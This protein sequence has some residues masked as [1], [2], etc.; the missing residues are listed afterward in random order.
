MAEAMAQKEP[1]LAGVKARTTCRACDSKRLV[2]ALDFGNPFVSN[3]ADVPAAKNWPR[4]PLEVVLC[5]DCTL[6][7]LRHTTPSDW[8]YR[9]YWYKSGVNGAMREAL[10]DITREATEFVALRSGDHV[11]DIGCNDGTLLRSY[12]TAGIERVGFEPAENLAREASSDGAN[13]IINDFFSAAPVA[14][15]QFRII[16]S[17]AMFYD[18]ESPNAF[19]ADAASVLAKDGVW[20]IEM[21][22]L[23][24]TLMRNAF[25]AVCHEH[26]EY[27]SLRS[28][29]P[30]LARH[31]LEVADVETNEVNGGSFRVYVVHR[32]SDSA[33]VF[34]R[35]GRVEGARASERRLALEQ[36]ATY[37]EFG[38]RVRQVGDRLRAFLQKERAR[39]KEISAYG[40]STKGNTLLQVFGL[41]QHLIRSAAERN[42]EKWGKYTVGTWIPIVSEAEARAHADYFLVLP[43][44]FLADIRSR[45]REFLERGGKLIA[46][47]PEP[48]VIDSAGTHRLP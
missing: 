22:Y 28:L 37:E 13:R 8:L 19:V 11:L 27:Y 23:P 20:I 40:A 39:G 36:A 10:A 14:G 3:F 12:E 31:G 4:V 47:L 26:L 1:L 32:G 15:E 5:A 25:D 33:G 44:H 30:L 43:W 38:A 2:E 48:R 6:L 46:P 7:Q 34:E 18:L 45:E 21:H 16:T 9:R 41:D 42:P 24:L 29:E 17:I 35:W